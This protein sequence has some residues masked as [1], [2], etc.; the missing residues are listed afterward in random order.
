MPKD[1]YKDFERLIV[2]HLEANRSKDCLLNISH[3]FDLRAY[4]HYVKNS[5]NHYFYKGFYQNWDGKRGSLMADNRSRMTFRKGSFVPRPENGVQATPEEI[6]VERRIRMMSEEEHREEDDRLQKLRKAKMKEL[7]QDR[8]KAEKNFLFHIHKIQAKIKERQAVLY[9]GRTF[10]SFKSLDVCVA[11]LRMFQSHLQKEV[12]ADANDPQ[13]EYL[14]KITA[15]IAPFI[16]DLRWEHMYIKRHYYLLEISFVLVVSAVN[17]VLEKMYN[18]NNLS[19]MIVYKK[20]L[21]DLSWIFPLVSLL[22]MQVLL[23]VISVV[24]LEKMISR[25]TFYKRSKKV[26]VNFVFFNFFMIL[27]NIMVVFYGFLWAAHNLGES[28]TED[29]KYYFNFYINFQWIKNSLII[30]FIPLLQR[31]LGDL[32]IKWLLIPK[33]SSLC[34]KKKQ[35]S[36]EPAGDQSQAQSAVEK[37][38]IAEKD[39]NDGNLL[40]GMAREAEVEDDP[41]SGDFSSQEESEGEDEHSQDDEGSSDGHKRKKLV[42]D[43]GLN[44]SYLIQVAFF[45]GFYLSFCSPLLLLITLAGVIV[46]YTLEDKLLKT[47]YEKTQY[48]SISNLF[49]TL[50]WSFVAF[51]IGIVISVQNSKIYLYIINTKSTEISQIKEVTSFQNMIGYCNFV[52][53]IIFFFQMGTGK[54]M[55]RVLHSIDTLK[56]KFGGAF[57]K[58]DFDKVNYLS[59]NPFYSF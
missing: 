55:F 28:V 4:F 12:L 5:K 15:K 23:S 31:L 21:S 56:R 47:A 35:K 24:C 30:I 17:M 43:F 44:A 59:Q 27:N 54:I 37:N 39:L 14:L 48:I 22:A 40:Q 29:K 45:T 1:K 58:Y 38:D 36:E 32:I 13:Y 49:V 25:Y 6:K 33:I 50:R 52:I 2:S 18:Q 46:N 3:V 41:V 19:E 9:L 51:C 10:V 8:I 7:L 20:G 11:F 57:F 16:D 26:E 34:K 42:H 53:S